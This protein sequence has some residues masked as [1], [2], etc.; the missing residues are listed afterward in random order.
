M[1]WASA[2]I[3]EF[4]FTPTVSPPLGENVILLVNLAWSAL[5]YLRPRLLV[6]TDIG[7]DTD[8]Q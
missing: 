4:G 8:D 5:L 7:Q 3:S 1:L 6:L 2:R